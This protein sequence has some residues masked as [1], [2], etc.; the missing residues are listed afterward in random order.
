MHVPELVYELVLAVIAATI[1][2]IAA[3]ML[4]QPAI[5]GYLAAGL[6]IG[7]YTPGPTGD[8]HQ[9]QTLAEVGVAFLLFAIGTEVSLPKLRE[10]GRVAVFGGALQLVVTIVLG[11]LVARSLGYQPIA[12]LF[13]GSLIALSSTV[14][15]SRALADR[16]ELGSL[17]GRIALGLLVVQDLSLVPLMIILPALA[18]PTDDV[19]GQLVFAL[20]KA[21][22]ILV[23]VYLVG[24]RLAPW[25]LGRVADLH[26]RELFML[27]V[28]GLTL[29]TAMLTAAAG[30]SLAFGAFLA[31]LVL[32]ES[33][34]GHLVETEIAP[35]RDVFATLFFVSVG[36]LVDPFTL[37]RQWPLLL[38]VVALA[39]IGKGLVSA[40][41]ALLFGYPGRVAVLA[42]LSLVQIGE[43]S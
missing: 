2:G 41:I 14:V 33:E 3:R 10:V 37:A 23:G 7:P 27:T 24:T 17:H 31:G 13:F 36:M 19:V 29:G 20:G 32:A 42:G 11:A 22:A 8:V 28:V 26:S 25:L 40:A 43:F 35:I 16:G 21:I 5:V 39:I 6:A 12:G 4:R 1:G 18:S 15:A 38:I 34:W 30:L 9:V